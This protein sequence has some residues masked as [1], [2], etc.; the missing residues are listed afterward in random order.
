[1]FKHILCPTDMKERSLVSL[2][3][4][5]QIAHQ[6]GSKITLLNVH[7]EFMNKEERS[8]LRVSFGKLKEKYRQ[9][10]VQCREEMKAM[11]HSL[12]AEDVELNYVLREGKPETAIV[13]AARDLDADLIVICTD[14][15]DNLK[16][17]VTGTITEHVINNTSCP[18]LVLHECPPAEAEG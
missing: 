18:V 7:D 11:V 2:K 14:G 10:A 17:F 3:K 12:H 5:V 4:A 1:M 9:T 16:D 13:S 15:R 8:M 6:F